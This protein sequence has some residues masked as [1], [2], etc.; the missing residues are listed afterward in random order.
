MGRPDDLKAAFEPK[1]QQAKPQG[2]SHPPR[3]PQ[4]GVDDIDHSALVP[5]PGEAD[6]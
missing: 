3:V 5:T 4:L 6:W 2:A 1:A